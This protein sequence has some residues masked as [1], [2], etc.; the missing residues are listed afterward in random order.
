MLKI[1]QSIKIKIGLVTATTIIILGAI[2]CFSTYQI[3]LNQISTKHEADFRQIIDANAHVIERDFYNSQILVNKISQ[4]SELKSFLQQDSQSQSQNVNLI[5]NLLSKY[6]LDDSYSAIYL[7]NLSGQAVAST[8]LT[9]IGQNYEFRQY[10][11]SS[12]AGLEYSDFNFG[13]TSL[14]PGY[15]F[16]SPIKND[17]DEIIGVAVAKLKPEKIQN[18]FKKMINP[19]VFDLML[20]DYFGVIV[21]SSRPER[22]FHSLGLLDPSALAII[23]HERKYPG[24]TIESLQ[25]QST[26]DIIKSQPKTTTVEDVEDKVDGISEKLFVA[27]IPNTNFYI[28]SEVSSQQIVDSA[29]NVAKFISLMV[30]ITAITALLILVILLSKMLNPIN[31][32]VGMASQISQGDFEVDN[33]I[34]TGDELS[35]LAQVI[36]KMAISLKEKYQD[37]GSTVAKRTKE[38]QLQTTTLLNTQL[39][40]QNLLEDTNEAKQ[41][42][43]SAANDLQKFKKAVDGASDHIIITDAEGIILYA[44]PAVTQLTGFS[45]KEVVGKKAGSKELWGGVMPPEF[46]QQMWQT[47]KIDKKTFYGEINNKRKNGQKYIAMSSITPILDSTG[48]V[49]FFVGIER[50]AT[51]EREVDRMKTEFVS[52]ASHQLRTPLSAMKWFSEM[53]LT[54]DAGKLNKEQSEFVK[55][56]YDSNERMIQLVK[57][58]LDISRIESGRII[59]DP[60]PTD[61]I[62][63]VNTVIQE[64][65]IKATAKKQKI[66]FKY[67][68]KLPLVNLDTSLVRNVYLNLLTNAIKYTPEKGKIT[69][70]IA[71]KSQNILSTVADNGFGIPKSQQDQTF[72]KFFRASNAVKKETEGTGLGLYLV[73]SIVESSG[74]SIWFQSTEG[75]GTTFWFSLPIAGIPAKKGQIH[76]GS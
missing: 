22:R 18:T 61:L 64:V 15:Y 72:H 8:E 20:V 71:K 16:S 76:L 42:A 68:K 14:L 30:G 58:L 40:I 52:F 2:A 66:I 7:L 36:Q 57:D 59:I 10:Y 24:T 38:L 55:N 26:L 60:T 33:P 9:F 49:I 37:L 11:K 63:L 75:K 31:N 70:T 4:D 32:L 6:N 12:L 34:N 27:P 69:I 13:T 47:I 29:K 65:G 53:L 35:I 5:N 21:E 1:L 39:A 50:D 48:K 67:V 62:K 44:N 46:Y 56:I 74:G 41:S 23:S 43:E 28:I 3:V 51:V 73:K 19:N 54:G 45:Q 25:Y 17:L